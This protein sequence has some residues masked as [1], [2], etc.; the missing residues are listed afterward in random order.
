MKVKTWSLLLLTCPR[1]SHPRIWGSTGIVPLSAVS[2]QLHIPL[3]FP[4]AKSRH[5]R[6]TSQTVCIFESRTTDRCPSSTHPV[7]YR[8][9]YPGLIIFILVSILIIF[10][11]LRIMSLRHTAEEKQTPGSCSLCFRWRRAVRYTVRL[12]SSR[13]PFQEAGF[14]L[15]VVAKRFRV[16]NLYF[17]P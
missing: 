15:D 5:Y 4:K 2:C 16:Y 1:A 8:L 14:G 17:R 12:V 6:W 11:V 10:P 3:L 7:N 9:S 13:Y